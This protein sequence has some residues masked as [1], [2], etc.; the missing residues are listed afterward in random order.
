MDTIAVRWLFVLGSRS[1]GASCNALP[2]RSSVPW[3]PLRARQ[4]C[5]ICV[6]LPHGALRNHECSV[7][8]ARDPSHASPRRCSSAPRLWSSAPPV[9]CSSAPSPCCRSGRS[10]CCT[11]VLLRPR[12][13]MSLLRRT[14][15]R[16]ERCCTGSSGA[17]S[18]AWDCHE[19]EAVEQSLRVLPCPRCMAS[20]PSC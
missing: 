11:G 5:I 18:M 6:S 7:T 2:A 14:R 9:G 4:A 19:C 20:A 8:G 15:V 10:P 16:P 17:R 1:I 12:L 13:G 3:I